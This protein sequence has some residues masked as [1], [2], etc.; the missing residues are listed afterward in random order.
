MNAYTCAMG[1]CA[2]GLGGGLL[3]VCTWGGLS[4]L[5][6]RFLLD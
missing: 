1:F 4:Y 2:M 3:V 5:A 6:W